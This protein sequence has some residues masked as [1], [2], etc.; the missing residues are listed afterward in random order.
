MEPLVK[1]PLRVFRSEVT[2]ITCD[3][4]MRAWVGSASGK[5]KCVAL[6]ATE[7][8]GASRGSQR[9]QLEVRGTL[10]WGGPTHAEVPLR[11]GNGER[12]RRQEAV[13]CGKAWQGRGY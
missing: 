2:A 12:A 13:E 10:A 5:V 8:E 6:Q 9:R 11:P 7:E 4:H 1:Y 3:E